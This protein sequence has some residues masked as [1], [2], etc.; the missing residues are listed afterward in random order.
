MK[1]LQFKKDINAPAEKVYD[2]MLGIS[3]IETYEQWTS[4]FN[5]T[6]SYEGS[7]G[8]GSKIYFVGTDENGKKGGM[9]SEIA[10]SI[11]FQFVSIRHYGILDGEKEITEGAEVEKWAGGHENYSFKEN[12]GIT[13]VTVDLDTTEDFLDYMDQTYPKALDKLKEL[14]EK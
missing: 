12:N 3:N 10:D 6:S 14:C 5:P 2:T 1:K 4:E 8:K 11:P 7:W 9:V 13:T